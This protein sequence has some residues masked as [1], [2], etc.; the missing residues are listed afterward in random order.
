[1]PLT[2]NNVLHG[3]ETFTIAIVIRGLEHQVIEYQGLGSSAPW[4]NS[5]VKPD[6]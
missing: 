5:P 1:M 3:N 6:V 2:R 4:A